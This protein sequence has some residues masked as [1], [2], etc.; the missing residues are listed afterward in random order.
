MRTI[1]L[2]SALFVS[3][4]L[5][6]ANINAPNLHAQTEQGVTYDQ[7]TL[8]L[9]DPVMSAPV[10][11]RFSDGEAD[12][13]MVR[14]R[15]EDGHHQLHAFSQASLAGPSP[16][17]S[18]KVNMPHNGV[19]YAHGEMPDGERERLL[20]LTD[21]GV[22]IYNLSTNQF[23]M[24]VETGSIYRQ[25]TDIRLALGDFAADL[26]DDGRF[27]LTIPN[28]DGIHTWIQNPDGSFAGPTLLPVQPEMRLTGN[29]SNEDVSDTSFGVSRARTPSFRVFPHYVFDATGDG[30]PDL[31]FRIGKALEVFAMGPTGS[32]STNA[33]TVNLPFEMRGNRWIDDI[34]ADE[35]NADQSNFRDVSLY[36]IVDLD[37][38]GIQDIVTVLNKAN[39]LFDREQDFRIYKGS[40]T[41][42]L[43]SYKAAPDHTLLMKGVGGLGLRD[44]NNDG[45]KDL[46][47]ASTKLSLTKVVGFLINKTM[48]MRTTVQLDN[49]AGGYVK[50]ENYNRSHS[51]GIDLSKGLTRNPPLVYADFDGD[52]AIDLLLGKNGEE[53]QLLRGDKNAPFEN[54]L[55]TIK[56]DLPSEGQLVS[57]LEI[58]DDGRADIVLRYSRFGYDGEEAKKK[59]IVFLSQ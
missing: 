44:I 30:K 51:I 12:A 21:E 53:L 27:D 49:G 15:D 38:D 47:V 28:F 55:T 23:D 54:L 57:S 50:N 24:L 8:T 29:F 45:R 48:K 3:T 34:R 42:G 13:L 11:M 19:L 41:G 4:G 43:I 22:R 37:D 26:N 17:A 18:H 58:N 59:L 2:F 33:Q 10:V 25:G 56:A 6:L 36:R 32:F 14:T 35:E 7:R 5:T 39:G 40:V 1:N 46:V 20:V 31:V 9:S 52:D 16:K